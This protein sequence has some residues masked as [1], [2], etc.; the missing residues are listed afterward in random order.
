MA[1]SGFSLLVILSLTCMAV[2]ASLVLWSQRS[3]A[4]ASN[5]KDE[6]AD[7]Y[8]SRRPYRWRLRIFAQVL[9][10][11][12]VIFAAPIRMNDNDLS[13]SGVDGLL[14]LLTTAITLIGFGPTRMGRYDKKLKSRRSWALVA[15]VLLIG[16]MMYF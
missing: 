7:V 1:I 15:I 3:A 5:Q 12:A 9:I 4:Y 6:P 8:V 11:M 13:Y 2:A 10:I 14:A 16:L